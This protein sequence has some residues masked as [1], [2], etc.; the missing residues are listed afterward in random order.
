MPPR[1]AC[2]SGRLSLLLLGYTARRSHAIRTAALTDIL[3]RSVIVNAKVWTCRFTRPLSV[4]RWTI[5]V[6]LITS[7]FI[8]CAASTMAPPPARCPDP[9]CRQGHRLTRADRQAEILYGDEE[10]QT[11]IQQRRIGIN[12]TERNLLR[13]G[14]DITEDGA[15]LCA[16]RTDMGSAETVHRC[17]LWT[18]LSSSASR[19][20]F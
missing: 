1:S 4:Q 11:F 12:S 14:L 18:R 8:A 19:G 2:S 5:S 7:T 3:S 16:T 17:C 15:P 9:F 13:S 10:D 20:A 6:A